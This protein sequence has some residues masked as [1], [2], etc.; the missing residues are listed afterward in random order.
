VV[1]VNVAIIGFFGR[2]SLETFII[3]LS[4]H[5]LCINFNDIF[6]YQPFELEQKYLH[7]KVDLVWITFAS[8]ELA[9][10]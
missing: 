4:G 9:P 8:P 5:T 6:L 10:T 1:A 7:F 2:Y 3:L